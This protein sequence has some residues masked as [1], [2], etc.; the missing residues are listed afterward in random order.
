MTRR[1]KHPILAI[2]LL[3]CLNLF[4]QNEASK[5]YFGNQ[6]GLNFMTNPPTILT[7]GAMNV[8][9]GCASIADGAGNLLM[10]T[11]GVTV[12]N[13]AHLIMANGTGLLG[14]NTPCQSSI[15]IQRPGSNTLYYIFT[16]QG[17]NGT[18][19]LNY[20]I[21]D[22]SL[23]NGQGSVTVKNANLYSGTIAEKL[24]ATK[25]CNG[26]DYWVLAKD[27]SST[28]TISNFRAYQL[29]SAGVSTT[30]VLSPAWQ[31]TN[32]TNFFYDI[33][34][35]KIAPNG[36]KLGL[37]VYG[38]YNN[39]TN[40]NNH[41]F[42]LWDFN[43]T[44]G[45]VSNSL[46]LGQFTGT[47]TNYNYGYGVEFSPD[48]TKLYGSRLYNNTNATGGVL[49]YNLCAGSPTAIQASELTVGTNTVINS[50][51]FGSLQLGPNGKIYC[52]NWTGTVNNPQAISVIN[53]PNS[54]G[55][56]CGF[57]LHGQSISPKIC[58]YGLPNFPSNFFAQ[59][60]PVSPYT[61]TVSNTYGCQGVL[62][63]SPLAPNQTV[64]ACS[65]SGFSLTNLLWN[66]GDPASGTNN[67]STSPTPIHNFNTLG[68]YTVSLILYY[69]CGGGT[70]TLK[71]VVNVNLPCI[72]VSSS[73]I[74]CANLGSATVQAVSGVG[75]FSYTW[76]PT[77]QTNSVAT[78]LSPGGYTITVFDLGNNF[79]YTAST[80]FNS[81][82]PLTGSVSTTPSISCFGAQT[83]TASLTNLAGGSG[84]TNISW[85]NPSGTLTGAYTASLSAGIWSIN[86]TDALTGCQINQ[87]F[88]VSQP[89]ALSLPLSG[90]S[91]S[92]CAGGT[93]QVSGLASGGTPGLL[94]PYSYTWTNGSVAD[95]H[96]YTENSSGTFVYTL[97]AKDS[98]DCIINNTISVAVI[99]NP[100]ISVTSVSVC[101]LNTGTITASGASTYTWQNA[102]TGS[103]FA[104]APT[105]N[106][107]YSL[108]GMLAGCTST[109]SGNINLYPLP[110][111]QIAS[112]SPVC[113]GQALSFIG[114][115]GT[116]YVWSG[117]NAFASTLTSGAIQ[118]AAPAISGIY[119]LTVTSAV[120]CTMSTSA[121]LTVHPTPTLSA[122]GANVCS[123]GTINLTANS[124]ANSAYF[125][126]GPQAYQSTAQNPQIIQ[127]NVNASGQYNVLVI[128]PQGCT[129]TT[130]VNVI[131]T[132]LPSP[133]I[134]S[135]APLCADNS[136][137]LST[138]GGASYFWIGPNGFS[139]TQQ[140]PQLPSAQSNASGMYTV[141]VTLGPCQTATT[142]SV[143][144]WPLPLP[145]ISVTP[146]VCETK[147]LGLFGAGGPNIVN[148]IWNGPSAF[149]AQ[150]QNQVR[151]NSSLLYTGIYTL[152]VSD[153]NGCTNFTSKAINIEANP[154]VSAIGAT[155]C[156]NATTTLQANGAVSYFWQG[157]N[158]FQSSV[159]NPVLSPVILLSNGE[160]TVVGTAANTCTSVAKASVLTLELPQPTIVVSPSVTTC[161]GT[162]F[163]LTG[164]GGQRY[165]WYGPDKIYAE[166]K[167]FL[168]LPKHQGQV[169]TFSLVAQDSIGCK[170]SSTT[171][172]KIYALP[173]GYLSASIQEAC[174]P[175]CTDFRFVSLTASGSKVSATYT[176]NG[177][178]YKN[179]FTYCYRDAGDY[180]FKG[181]IYDSLT[182]CVNTQ[183]LTTKAFAKPVAAFEISPK[184]PDITNAVL[185]TAQNMDAKGNEVFNQKDY[186]SYRWNISN[187]DRSAYTGKTFS[188]LF[189]EAGQYA[190]ALV[191]QDQNNCSDTLVKT[192]IIKEDFA[193]F[194]P[195]SFTPNNDN[196]NDI[197]YPVFRS[198]RFYTLQI[199]DRWGK[200]IYNGN[201]LSPGWDGTYNSE[202]CA[203]DVYNYKIVVSSTD[204]LQRVLNGHVTLLR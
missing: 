128:S 42:E 94:T 153:I 178:R 33:G 5:W 183:T 199:F 188:H 165:F 170:N 184:E 91:A 196:L 198:E 111:A 131:V 20:S 105:A 39:F 175:Y 13:S 96:V 17:T 53:S 47:T 76:T 16:V 204:G 112:N 135:N 117:P 171:V 15:I 66:F 166:G 130:A 57:V 71:Q 113:N 77:N 58:Y 89:P 1:K 38:Y 93:V 75:P 30:G 44:T 74:T 9:E 4:S 84:S 27:W 68:T 143:T 10:Y 85:Y 193:G 86:A 154:S 180:V 87:S 114:S 122:T 90:S 72:S 127:P 18:A 185:F 150:G 106:T 70:D 97:T 46:A 49:Q 160:Y 109:A 99:P 50:N 41:S 124:F 59:P 107:Q 102:G 45:V 134:L 157:P 187:T 26:V 120:G 203:S 88:F 14:S 116:G 12:Y 25:H 32:T 80:F 140:N 158:V 192:V 24:T 202:L 190:V 23:A 201:Q 67:T 100:T 98:L 29:T 195:N 142:R 174:V 194:I 133:T 151:N 159:K 36:K 126:S 65:V 52:A 95:T 8:F 148:W 34:A 156:L 81:L 79:T 56:A 144:V 173:D 101:P 7:N 73:S 191:V 200:I 35:M 145:T 55:T 48:G 149:N 164:F 54:L 108:V 28:T 69:S 123:N 181:V 172:L 162:T 78:G 129:N 125:W 168:M 167:Q 177:T 146:V 63:Q 11:D 197:F 110:N 43:N 19:G 121:N 136:L 137:I 169:G 103:T 115:G 2:L 61:F 51:W 155:V 189:G 3:L 161:P 40:L 118:N 119:N 82:I 186:S 132:A 176:V 179:K 22:M 141:N 147:T 92:I 60:P 104:D 138:S 37:A 31:W 64:T 152:T 21:V 182:G 6:A 83:G 163:T 139:S 62:F